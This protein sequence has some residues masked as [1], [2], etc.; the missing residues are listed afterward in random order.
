MQS[1]SFVGVDVA[2]AELVVADTAK[3]PAVDRLP[4]QKRAVQHWLRS[5]PAGTRIG[6]ESTGRYHELLVQLACDQ[7]LQ[8]YLINPRDLHH[9]GKAVHGGRKTD[10]LDAMLIARYLVN[11][12]P[13]L[14]PYRPPTA[15]E[16][17]LLTLQRQR[18]QVVTNQVALRQSLAG[19]EAACRPALEG[20]LRALQELA[21]TLQ[22]RIQALIAQD[23]ERHDLTQRLRSAPGCGPLT[24][25]HLATLLPRLQPSNADALISYVG[26]D[27]KPRESGRWRGQRKL[28]K[29][30]PAE[31]RRL[32]Y[33]AAKAAARTQPEW[34]TRY[35]ALLDQGRAPTEAVNILARR[36]LKIL[37]A[38]YK[39]GSVYETGRSEKL[40]PA[41]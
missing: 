11:E 3:G 7:G 2:K 33:L 19:I 39:H 14:R 29:Q 37:Y 15:A 31:T 6:V 12:Y 10:P 22:T 21:D 34:Q 28:S 32:L 38:M 35:Q 30:G 9:Y 40:A 4:N 18:A 26:L 24:S 5:L 16:R 25:A 17:S 8:V 27:P 20:A 13:R 36:L 41:T 1:A 23:A